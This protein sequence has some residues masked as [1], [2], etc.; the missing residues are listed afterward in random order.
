MKVAYT[1][2]KGEKTVVLTNNTSIPYTLRRGPKGAGSE[3]KPFHSCTYKVAKNKDLE[4]TILNLWTADE[5]HPKGKNLKVTYKAK[6][7]K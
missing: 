6:Q 3:L 4:L 2:S 5:Q 7:L 1:S